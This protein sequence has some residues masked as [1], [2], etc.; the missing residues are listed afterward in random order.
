MSYKRVGYLSLY[1]HSYELDSRD[2][3]ASA[4]ET[5]PIYKNVSMAAESRNVDG[6]MS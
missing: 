5:T 4:S 1:K 6:S 3:V 2:T